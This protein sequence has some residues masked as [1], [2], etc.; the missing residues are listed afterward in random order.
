MLCIGLLLISSISIL[1]NPTFAQ[2]QA[3]ID[4]EQEVQRLREEIAKLQKEIEEARRAQLTHKEKIGIIEAKLK[5]MRKLT[6]ALNQQLNKSTHRLRDI[7]KDQLIKKSDIETYEQRLK[8][9]H[10]KM[11]MLQAVA[12]EQVI[13]RYKHRNQKKWIVLISSNNLK[14]AL[15]RA[16]LLEQVQRFEARLYNE[17]KTERQ[18]YNLALAELIHEYSEIARSSQATRIEVEKAKKRKFELELERKTL[19]KE[20]AQSKTEITR[21]RELI[22]Q[23]ERALKD[24]QAS[25]REIENII[26]NRIKSNETRKQQVS[27]IL[28]KTEAITGKAITAGSLSWPVKGEVVTQFGIVRDPIYNTQIEN[29][30]IDVQVKAG[31]PVRAAADGKVITTT[32]MRGFESIIIIEHP[33]N[34]FTVYSRLGEIHVKVGETVKR[35]Q[36]IGKVGSAS[37]NETPKLHFEVWIQR[38]KK[39]PL[40]Y[41]EAQ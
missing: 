6:S 8:M 24:R 32:W 23:H 19:E 17:L 12:R 21:S 33:E 27:T 40:Q 34:G 29:P 39:N 15:K 37:N 36:I 13:H 2:E 18:Q 1:I 9:V 30:G 3:T 14:K 31:T 28:P 16:R 10:I 26:A 35:G 22:E 7:Q 20:M 41:L 11:S 38:S 5:Q 25:L 4:G